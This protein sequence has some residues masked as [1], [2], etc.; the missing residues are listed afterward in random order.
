[1]AAKIRKG[2]TVEVLTGKNRGARGVVLRVNREEGRV[3]VERVNVIKRHQKPNAQYRQGG[4]I[5]REAPID[6][7][8]VALVHRGEATRVSFRVVDGRKLRWSRQHD[9]AIDGG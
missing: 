3:V 8:N 6:L 4:I 5:E 1:V 9:E 7:S 2:D